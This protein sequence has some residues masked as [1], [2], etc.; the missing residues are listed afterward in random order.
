MPLIQRAGRRAQDLSE[1]TEAA[2]GIAVIHVH[3]DDISAGP[4]L[5]LT[6][7]DCWPF[8]PEMLT[9]IIVDMEE[10]QK[11]HGIA[12]GDNP[13]WSS[14]EVFLRYERRKNFLSDYADCVDPPSM[15]ALESGE[16]EYIALHVEGRLGPVV[17]MGGERLAAFVVTRLASTMPLPL[18][19]GYLDE[20][21][22]MV[23]GE[24]SR[25]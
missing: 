23:S 20:F 24:P 9:G 15:R 8:G 14:Q 21:Q 16:H 10:W 1:F 19:F 5:Y 22:E 12:P 25:H 3:Y 6:V 17:G 13:Q 18:T 4:V 11:F 2:D 7:G